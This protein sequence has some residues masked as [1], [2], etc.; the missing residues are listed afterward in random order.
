MEL[1]SPRLVEIQG[2]GKIGP[3][4]QEFQDNINFIARNPKKNLSDQTFPY[5]NIQFYEVLSTHLPNLYLMFFKQ[6]LFAIFFYKPN[7]SKY[8]LL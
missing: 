3:L 1:K 6:E 4:N 5:Q 8:F 7:R 2:T